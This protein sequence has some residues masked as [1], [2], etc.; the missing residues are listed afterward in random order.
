VGPVLIR[1]TVDRNLEVIAWGMDVDLVLF[2]IPS[3][4]LT[5]LALKRKRA[6]K[7]SSSGQA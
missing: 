4:I 2:Y 3:K 7:K 5:H 6:K 1:F